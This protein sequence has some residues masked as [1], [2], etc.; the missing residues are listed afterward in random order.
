MLAALP[1]DD[2]PGSA[3]FLVSAACL[4][5]HVEGTIGTHK[6]RKNFVAEPIP[7]SKAATS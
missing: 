3:D 5:R 4:K 2:A 7:E 1:N 6:L